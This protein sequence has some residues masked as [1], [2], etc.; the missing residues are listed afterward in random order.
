[1]TVQQNGRVARQPR[2]IATRKKIIDAG[3]D[4]FADHGYGETSLGDI[5]V[6]AGVT[7]GAFY[8]HFDSKET[9]A[10]AI[11]EQGWPKAVEVLDAI[12]G[13]PNPGLERVI[14]MT[15]SLSALMKRDRSVWIAN[16]LNQAFGQLSERGRQEFKDHA[17]EFIRRIGQAIEPG[18]LK[19]EITPEDVGNQVWIVLHGCHLLSDALMD[20]VIERL[21]RSWST[22]LPALVPAESL[23]YFLTFADRAAGRH[24]QAVGF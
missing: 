3:V 7:T 20:D 13:S 10:W 16:H 4:L 21:A 19:P 23:P 17:Q 9:L 24:G 1:M 14:E 2:A 15:F 18:D 12:L 5:T 8:H 6:R 11:I 22:L